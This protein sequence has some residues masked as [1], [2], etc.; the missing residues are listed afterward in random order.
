M[1]I[2]APKSEVRKIPKLRFPGFSGDWEEKKLNS[3][4]RFISGQ[5]F[6]DNEQ[7]GKA[8]IP[9]YKVSDMNLPGN[10]KIMN[11]ANHYVTD[12]QIKRLKYKVNEEKSIIF[13]KVGAAIFLERK[14]LAEK[15][16]LDNNMMAFIPSINVEFI[17]HLFA[18]IRLSQYA[19][20]G[21]LP[22][23]NSTDLGIIKTSIPRSKLE[24]QKIADFLSST[25]QWIETLRSQKEALES[26]K[27]GMMQKIFHQEIRF[28]DDEGKEFPK[29]KEKKLGEICGNI[30]TGKLDANAMVENGEYRFY[31]CAREYYRINNYAFDTEAL[32]VSGNGANVGYIHYY[33]GKFNAYQ[34]TYV[35]FNFSEDIHFI[36]VFMDRNLQERI[37]VEVNA[38]NTP[39]IT[40]GTL[41]EME[42]Y[43]PPTKEEQQAIADF[44]TSID[45]LIESKQKQITLA[46]QWK[47][48]LMQNLFV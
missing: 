45:K 1:P 5:G 12:E 14:R 40:M 4:G 9:F 41:T 20:V 17:Q 25:D 39:Y 2:T 19:Q 8:G 18:T 33:K 47:K 15:F 26:Y 27:K 23:Y 21:A 43:V 42:I 28:K 30:T 31:T 22:S 48:G 10:E 34:R 11:S 37:R 44:L 36:K 46:E 32:L 29:W 13:A 6:S 24:Q 35:L 3:L 38:G 7:G 16:L